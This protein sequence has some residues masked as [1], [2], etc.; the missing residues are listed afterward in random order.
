M[1]KRADWL[2]WSMQFLAGLGF[3]ALIGICMI[4]GRLKLLGSG[5]WDSPMVGAMFIIGAS[6]TTAGLASF[7]G[8]RLWLGSSYR[9]YISG[10]SLRHSDS[11]RRASILSGTLGVLVM[12][13]AFALRLTTD[14]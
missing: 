3:G 6:L 12:A 7:F 4:S 8:D 1:H 10:E 13:V 9:P 5:W 11:S 2:A 14:S